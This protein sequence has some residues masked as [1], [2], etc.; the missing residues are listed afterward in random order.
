MIK[1]KF[2]KYKYLFT[3]LSV[4]SIIVASC[5]YGKTA[6]EVKPGE[7]SKT[8]NNLND[9]GVSGATLDS[10]NK[11]DLPNSQVANKFENGKR[12][13]PDQYANYDAYLNLNNVSKA[14]HEPPV[15]ESSTPNAGVT[16]PNDI[17]PEK[18]KEYDEKAKRL[19]L[20]TYRDAFGYGF[21][22][23][24]IGDDGKIGQGLVERNDSFGPNLIPAYQ[25]G[26]LGSGYNFKNLGDPSGFLGLPRT[27]LNDN[28]R[29]FS[30]TVYSLSYSNAF[31]DLKKGLEADSTWTTQ[32]KIDAKYRLFLGTTWILDYKLP[33]KT[34]EYPKTW[35]FAS[36]MHVLEN[37]LLDGIAGTDQD[38]R[39]FEHRD[40]EVR[41]N[42]ASLTFVNYWNKDATPTGSRFATTQP[43]SVTQINDRTDLGFKD[44][45]IHTQ[46]DFNK[47]ST[48]Y[49]RVNIDP[50]NIKPIF[51]GADFLK[52]GSIPKERGR[53]SDAKSMIDF[54]VIEIT[55]NNEQIAKWLTSDYANWPENEKYKFATTSL[56]N[57]QTYKDLKEDDLYAIGFPNSHDDYKIRYAGADGETIEARG[58]YVSYWTNKSGNYYANANPNKFLEDRKDKGGDLSWSN[59]RTF[60]NKPGVTDLLLSYPSFDGSPKVYSRIPYTNSGLGYLLD[61]FVP[62]G[63]ASGSRIIDGSGT[64]R[65]ILFGVAKSSTAGYAVAL[66]SE[67][68]DYEGLYGSYN[69][70]QYDLIYGGGKDQK[71]SYLDQLI[72]RRPNE[73]TWLFPKGVD[74]ANVPE[75]FKFKNA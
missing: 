1:A 2:R 12:Y 63:G 45:T 44:N 39:D 40:Y 4:S 6:T 46:D 10:K 55:F 53:F 38:F 65:G 32:Q 28:Y 33:E 72:K 42:L 35:Y 3:L 25:P 43:Q 73:K 61:N 50:K 37:L 24:N 48:P 47:I 69:L 5:N 66:R 36:N 17:D 54:G 27:I 26:F 29:K 60:V 16:N 64:I 21:L 8:S 58:D 34:G 18:L 23:P 30:K 62:S 68:M 70:P 74:R 19:G 59:T 7:K 41:T 13:V 22:L 67:G 9:G 49:V 20:P 51:L 11:I 57:D 31:P 14:R 56:L 71:D 75:Q 52:D 15:N